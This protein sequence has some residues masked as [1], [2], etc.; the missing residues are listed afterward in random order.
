MGWVEAQ[1]L[2]ILTCELL[3]GCRQATEALPETTGSVMLQISRAFPSWYSAS[4]AEASASSLPA[5]ASLSI[6]RSHSSLSHSRNQRRNSLKSSG[7][8]DLTWSSSFSM[9]FI[10]YL[11]SFTRAGVPLCGDPSIHEVAQVFRQGDV[12]GGH[13][14]CSGV[15][16]SLSRLARRCPSVNGAGRGL[17]VPFVCARDRPIPAPRRLENEAIERVPIRRDR[18]VPRSLHFDEPAAHANGA[19]QADR[20]HQLARHRCASMTRSRIRSTALIACGSRSGEPA[21]SLWH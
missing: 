6:W 20:R 14:R 8:S 4:A 13:G 17:A 21:Q 11:M 10:I 5:V 9:V 1:Q 18:D 2:I 3:H 15:W 7:E 19:I 12:H 16:Q